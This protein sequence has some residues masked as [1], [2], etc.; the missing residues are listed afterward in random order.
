MT[1]GVVLLLLD[2]SELN[3]KGSLL[4]LLTLRP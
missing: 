1:S 4:K 2:F 3:D